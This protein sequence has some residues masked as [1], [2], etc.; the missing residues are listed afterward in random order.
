MLGSL[1]RHRGSGCKRQLRNRDLQ[2]CWANVGKS[3]PCHIMILHVAFTEKMDVICVQEPASYP[4]TK[5]QN[6]P[7][8]DCFAPVDSW[9][10]MDPEQH[11][12]KRPHVMTY[13]W[14]GAGLHVTGASLI[15][16]GLMGGSFGSCHRETVQNVYSC[17][18]DRIEVYL[19]SPFGVPSI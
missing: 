14:K 3:T 19:L 4:G 17:N 2:V 15:V 10:S 18:H 5:T 1:S 16:I 13:I 8:Y 12:A 6:H 7:G 9:D 11:E